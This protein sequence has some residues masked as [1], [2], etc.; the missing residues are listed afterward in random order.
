MSK[1][2]ILIYVFIYLIFLENILHRACRFCT[3]NN[4]SLHLL[5]FLFAKCQP[6]QLPQ[7]F[8]LYQLAFT[9]TFTSTFHVLHFTFTPHA[10][11]F[12]A[13]PRLTSYA[14]LI[15]HYAFRITHPGLPPRP[16]E[17]PL[18]PFSMN[19]YD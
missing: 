2:H 19:N 13:F 15:T 7:L 12:T 5:S 3:I 1:K 6:N 18:Q 8:Q 11:R 16:F 14:L 9:L 10:L 17:L 4:N